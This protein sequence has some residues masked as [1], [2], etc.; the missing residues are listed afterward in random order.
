[1]EIEF[2]TRKKLQAILWQISQLLLS[3]FPHSSSESALDL[4]KIFFEQQFNRLDRAAKSTDR[5][6]LVQTCITINERI[7]QHLPYLGFLLRSTNI[8]NYFEAYHSYVGMAKALIGPNAKVIM[9]SQWNFSPLT[10]DGERSSR[11]CIDWNA[12]V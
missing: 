6:V 1:M 5:K 9:S 12:L 10:Y 4:I 7:Y 3:D 8:R 2:N 11:S